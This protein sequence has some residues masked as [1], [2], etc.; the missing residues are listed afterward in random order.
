LLM[1][2]MCAISHHQHQVILKLFLLVIQLVDRCKALAAPCCCQI[3][4]Y[5]VHTTY[6]GVA[7]RLLHPPHAAHGMICTPA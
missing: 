3:L 5:Q 1:L 2:S 6:A 4:L 7:T